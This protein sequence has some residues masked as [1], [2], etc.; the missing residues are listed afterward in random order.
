MNDEKKGQESLPPNDLDYTLY[1]KN[2]L[3]IAW[4][5]HHAGLDLIVLRADGTTNSK[6]PVLKDAYGQAH[7]SPTPLWEINK[8][9]KRGKGIGVICGATSGNLELLDF[10]VDCQVIFPKW[11]EKIDPQLLARLVIV[12][13]PSGGRHIPYRC[14]V[15]GRNQDL[16]LRPNPNDPKKP[17]KLI[18]TRGQGGYFCAVGNPLSIHP[19]R[20]PYRL[21]Q[22]SLLAIPIITPSEREALIT[23]ARAFNELNAVSS[24]S[25][26]HENANRGQLEAIGG[27]FAALKIAYKPNQGKSPADL[28]NQQTTWE[29]IL[30]PLGWSISHVSG[31]EIYWRKPGAGRGH[32][33]TTNCGGKDYFYC[34][35][36]SCP[37]IQ[38]RNN[39]SKFN[40]YAL[41]YHKGDFKKAVKQLTM[42]GGK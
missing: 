40:L 41:L 28:F 1:S 42:K 4:E 20:L 33:A 14:E 18:E 27:D 21:I 2:L 24:A 8:W 37:P 25:R 5:Y 30:E 36:T 34:F 35:T 23:Q 6:K 38:P 12:A 32:S 26:S 19:L 7:K 39:Y 3:K 31:E 29:S 9:I 17:Y 13:T 15:I 22:G 16:A 10:D 11:C